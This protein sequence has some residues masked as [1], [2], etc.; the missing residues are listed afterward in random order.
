LKIMQSVITQRQAREIT[1][2]RTPLVPVEYEEACKAL[3]ACS[4]I[5][6]AKYWDNK[7]DALAAW[8]KIYHDDKVTRQAR[9]LKL[10]A[11]RRMGEL[12]AE[13]RPQKSG[14]KKQGGSTLGPW[15]LLLESGLTL[16]E[17]TAARALARAP[18]SEVKRATEMSKPPSPLGAVRGRNGINTAPW[19]GKRNWFWDETKWRVCWEEIGHCIAAIRNHDAV[20]MAKNINPHA[21]KSL[22]AGPSVRTRVRELIEWL[23]AF[24]QAL[25]K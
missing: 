13:L 25:P 6:E 10:W 23:D 1:R 3:V 21:M 7:A 22:P 9:A 12:A 11:Y 2:G 5:D 18:L 15:S 8:A 4:T 16:A 17:T 14:G 24:E 19:G 20:L